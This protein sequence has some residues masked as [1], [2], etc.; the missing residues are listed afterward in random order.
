VIEPGIA[1]VYVLLLIVIYF[2]LLRGPPTFGK[3]SGS[4]NFAM[5]WLFA[6]A[7]DNFHLARSAAVGAVTLQPNSLKYAWILS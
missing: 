2:L 7:F 1:I 4:F 3:R 5:W 6:S